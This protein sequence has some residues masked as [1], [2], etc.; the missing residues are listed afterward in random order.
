MGV[1][2]DKWIFSGHLGIQC[3]SEQEQ[4]GCFQLRCSVHTTLDG[5]TGSVWVITQLN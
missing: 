1:S 3:Y 2:E 5:R 4:T